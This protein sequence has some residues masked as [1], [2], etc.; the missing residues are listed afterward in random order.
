[1]P[2]LA[3]AIPTLVVS[4]R[5]PCPARILRSPPSTARRMSPSVC[6]LA[7]YCRQRRCWRNDSQASPSVQNDINCRRLPGA[8][9]PGGSNAAAVSTCSSQ[10]AAE[11]GASIQSAKAMPFR[12]VM[13]NGPSG[14]TVAIS[15]DHPSSTALSAGSVHSVLRAGR[16]RLCGGESASWSRFLH[17]DL[18]R[19]LE[20]GRDAN[21]RWARI[22]GTAR[23]MHP[24]RRARVRRPRPI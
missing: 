18:Q 15:F 9:V 3:V 23:R 17:F 8:V 1:M 6:V 10:P 14:V 13:D 22:C 16:G 12:S 24:P 11:V 4:G 2:G 7:V 20:K 19:R 5:L 21:V